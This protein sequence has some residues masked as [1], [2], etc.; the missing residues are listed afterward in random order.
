MSDFEFAKDKVLMGGERRSLV[1]SLEE[2]R[3][4]AYHESGH[5][6]VAR[7]VPGTDPIHKVT[8]IPRGRALASPNSFLWTIGTRYAK[9]YLLSQIAVLMGGRAAEEVFLNHMTTGAGNDIERATE[10]AR[11]M[12]CE[13][14]MSEKLGPLTYGQKRSRS[15]SAKSLLDTKIILK[16][17]QYL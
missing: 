17:R 8:I 1:I 6:F 4:T 12:V 2:R 11:K 7:M 10:L 9:D 16:A 3:N 13:W 14:G 5:T 15:S